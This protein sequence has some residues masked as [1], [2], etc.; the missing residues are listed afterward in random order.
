MKADYV[1]NV[2]VFA[3]SIQISSVDIQSEKGM[4]MQNVF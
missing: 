3:S 2:V 1:V 4:V